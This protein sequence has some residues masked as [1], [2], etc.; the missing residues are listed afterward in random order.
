MPNCDFKIKANIDFNCENPVTKGLKPIGWIGNFEDLDLAN[1]Q[2]S[3]SNSNL[4]T[5]IALKNDARLYTIYQAGKQ[6][7]NGAIKEFVTGP[8]RNYWNKTV[9]FVILENGADVT[10][11]IIDPLTN[12]KYFMV[13]ENNYQGNNGDNAFELVGVE[14]GMSMTAGS[15]EKY[16]D[17]FGG[18][19]SLTMMEETAPTSGL[20]LLASTVDATRAGLNNLASGNT[21]S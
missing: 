4:Y 6:P 10:E 3:E 1:S 5:S 19:W 12:G 18:G 8:Y 14:T 2:K 16:N 20:F 9:P 7:F 21:F 11:N 17:E 13:L 15:D